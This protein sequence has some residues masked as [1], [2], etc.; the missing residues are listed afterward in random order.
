MN[1]LQE[2]EA[3]IDEFNTLNDE[4]FNIDSIRIEFSKQYKL[5]V[6]KEV[7]NWEK[8]KK[9][10]PLIPKLKKR[11]LVD[12]VTSAYR[13]ENH[14]IYYYNSNKDKPK[15]RKAVLVIFGM[16]QYHK[17]P[18]PKSI[19]SNLLQIMKDVSSIDVCLD[20]PYRPNLAPLSKYFALTPYITRDGVKTGTEYINDTYTPMLDK[21]VFYNKAV[22]NGLQGT[23][24]RIEATI[25]I[26]NFRALVLPLY[27]FKRIIDLVRIDPLDRDKTELIQKRRFYKGRS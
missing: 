8:I 18:P 21:V 17:D 2:L 10:S 24:W 7:G 11:L 27:E 20:L 15:Y 9:N 19:I 12:E 4:D 25:S 22:K 14:N 23:L 16:K 5:E 26:P 13:L 6:L 3:F 1:I